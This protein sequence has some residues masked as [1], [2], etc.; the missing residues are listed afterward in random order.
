MITDSAVVLVDYV[1]G[2]LTT[3]APSLGIKNV[4]IGDRQKFPAFPCITVEADTKQRELNGA[5][6]KTLVTFGVVVIVFHGA[7]R[8]LQDN[9]MDTMTLAEQIEGIIHADMRLG[10]N[11][12]DSMVSRV[13]YAYATRGGAL[14]RATRLTVNCTSQKMLPYPT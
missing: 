1:S 13:E 9:Y 12:I 3:A 8:D 5:P 7:A 11:V 4:W 10:E 2:L 6:R 14:L